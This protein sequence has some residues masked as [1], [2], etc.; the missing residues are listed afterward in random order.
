GIEGRPTLIG[1]PARVRQGAPSGGC[2]EIGYPPYFRLRKVVHDASDRGTVARGDAVQYG[3]SGAG[4]GGGAA[5][6]RRAGGEGDPGRRADQPRA[7]PPGRGGTGPQR[8]RF[9]R[10]VRGVLW[11][12]GARS[13]P[14]RCAADDVLVG[15]LARLAADPA[16]PARERAAGGV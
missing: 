11:V 6:A 5:D 12:G 7:V 16:R 1:D 13:H 3:V 4:G 10:G 9:V 14:E 15:L 8:T 2:L